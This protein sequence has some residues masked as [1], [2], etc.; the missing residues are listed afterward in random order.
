MMGSLI[1]ITLKEIG[2]ASACGGFEAEGQE[3]VASCLSETILKL[4]PW[5]GGKSI[6][7]GDLF[8]DLN[9]FLVLGECCP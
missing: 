1:G 2:G 6:P 7:Q 4:A 9:I 8:R 3:F 5:S